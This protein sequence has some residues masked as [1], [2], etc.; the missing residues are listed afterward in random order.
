MHSNKIILLFFT[1][2]QALIARLISLKLAKP[3]DKI[4]GFFLLAIYLMS[5]RSVISNDATLNSSTPK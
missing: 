4:I 1:D 5:L 3:V 2:I